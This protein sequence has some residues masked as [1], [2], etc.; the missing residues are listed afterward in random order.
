MLIVITGTPGAGK[1]T[2]AGILGRK[3]NAKIIHLREFVEKKKLASAFDKKMNAEVVDL[4]KLGKELEKE[5][6]KPGTGNWRR[7]FVIEGH[8]A[9]E[10]PLKADFVFVLRCK[11]RE[12]EKRMRRRG[13][14]KEKI[15]GNLLAEMLDYCVQKAEL[16]YPKNRIFEIETSRRV[17]EQTAG[18]MEKISLAKKVRS[19]KID[20]TKELKKFLKL[21]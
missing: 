20:Y 14:A 6:A 16:N 4:K 3:T 10:I 2:A 21:R 13:Y 1:T 12:L 8:L 7:S 5:I 17:A 15:N 18:V 11:P 9:C 19:G